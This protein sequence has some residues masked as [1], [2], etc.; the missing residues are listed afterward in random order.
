[1]KFYSAHRKKERIRMRIAGEK[2][3]CNFISEDSA[4]YERVGMEK[5]RLS[6]T[7]GDSYE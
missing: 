1:M 6:T 3:E 2:N 4:L 7:L 5:N